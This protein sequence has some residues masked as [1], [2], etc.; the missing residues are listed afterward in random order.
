M[1]CLIKH[2]V[3]NYTTLYFDTIQF[4]QVVYDQLGL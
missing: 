3:V 1:G 4:I 2:E